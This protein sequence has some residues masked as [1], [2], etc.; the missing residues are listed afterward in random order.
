MQR[1]LLLC[2]GNIG[3]QFYMRFSA[4]HLEWQQV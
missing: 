2:F 1:T 4:L 3:S